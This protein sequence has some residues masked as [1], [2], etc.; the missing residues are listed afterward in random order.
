[1]IAQMSEE[2]V[3]N[4]IV[5]RAWCDADFMDRLLTEPQVVL[6]EHDLEVPPGTQ[7]EVALG[8][9]VR[10]DEDGAVRR[11]VLPAGPSQELEE[12]ELG[13]DAV[14]WWCHCGACGAC[15]GCGCRC[16]CRCFC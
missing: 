14:A 7:V 15:G 10:I 4:Q 1:M 12:E 2:L 16:R 6:A 11:F 13:G 8:P 5:A 3:W 9:E